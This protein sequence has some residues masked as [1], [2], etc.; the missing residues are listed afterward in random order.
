MTSWISRIQDFQRAASGRLRVMDQRVG[1]SFPAPSTGACLS[2]RQC[3]LACHV[4]SRGSSTSISRPDVFVPVCPR[5]AR[6]RCSSYT[7]RRAVIQRPVP[8][9]PVARH[10]R[11]DPVASRTSARLA[12]L[13]WHGHRP[14]IKRR[15]RHREKTGF[16]YPAVSNGAK[17]MRAC[18]EPN[19]RTAAA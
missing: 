17:S 1:T 9:S 12:Q 18:V 10:G 19:A 8:T 3:L 13:K 14:P 11:T 2:T 7:P 5:P 16:G 15:P 4:L 6:L